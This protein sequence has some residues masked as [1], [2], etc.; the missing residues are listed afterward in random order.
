MTDAHRPAAAVTA[1][2]G[3]VPA[4]IVYGLY[5]AG[6]FSANLISPIGVIVAYVCRDGASPWVRTHLDSQIR[7]FWVVF[8]WAIAPLLIGLA[9]IVATAGIGI[10]A[11]PLIGLVWIAALV[12]T[13]IWFAIKSVIGLLKLVNGHPVS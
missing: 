1:D 11:A 2:D 10:I 9:V 5:I 13:T 4:F 6:V 7:M 12:I 8:W 3:K